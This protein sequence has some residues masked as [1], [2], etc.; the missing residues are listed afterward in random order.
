MQVR[1]LEPSD[2]TEL[3]PL[4]TQLGHPAT[5]ADIERRLRGFLQ[6]PGHALLGAVAPDGRVVGWIHVQTHHT[7]TADAYALIAGLVVDEHFRGA[8]VG[9]ALVEAAEAW[10]QTQGVDVVRVRSNIVRG[11][12]HHFYE[13]LGYERQKTSHVFDKRLASA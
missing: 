10:A 8:G 2:A 6:M 4:C 5:A 11:R 1:V 3:A 13:Q 7:V 9:R 12:A